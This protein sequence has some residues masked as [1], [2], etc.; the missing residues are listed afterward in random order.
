VLLVVV[1]LW[2][3]ISAAIFHKVRKRIE[4]NQRKVFVAKG[5]ELLR[6][7]NYFENFDRI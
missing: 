7:K 5:C 1:G 6:L 4:R 3:F 2:N